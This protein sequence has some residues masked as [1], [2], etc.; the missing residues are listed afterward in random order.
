MYDCVIV[1]LSEN[2]MDKLVMD[3]L[4]LQTIARI[5]WRLFC[6]CVLEGSEVDLLVDRFEFLFNSNDHK[7]S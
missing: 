5:H 6:N 4:Y 7:D 2:G 1:W 3:D